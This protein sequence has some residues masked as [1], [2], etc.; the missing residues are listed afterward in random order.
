M[1]AI[2]R[3]ILDQII[4]ITIIDQFIVFTTP[5]LI[6]CILSGSVAKIL[7]KIFDQRNRP[8]THP[9]KNNSMPITLVPSILFDNIFV[10]PFLAFSRYLQ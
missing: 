3:A 5:S 6:S 8:T 2:I 7:P 9:T 1:D 4:G 10:V